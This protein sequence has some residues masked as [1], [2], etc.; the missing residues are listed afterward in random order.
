[1]KK[2]KKSQNSDPI[3]EAYIQA[4]CKDLLKI[5][6]HQEYKLSIVFKYSEYPEKTAAEIGTNTVYLYATLSIYKPV[7]DAWDEND[8]REV[9]LMITHELCHLL[10][11]PQHI[12]TWQ[13]VRAADEAQCEDIRE[14]QTQRIANIILKLLPEGYFDLDNIL[15]EKSSVKCWDKKN[16]HRQKKPHHI[17]LK[18][19][20]QR[21][22]EEG[23]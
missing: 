18:G 20:K 5:I 13:L 14:R 8:L 6:L 17:R 23:L 15:K 12:F 21:T 1:M 4:L 16:T 2:I 19:S 11:E 9:G 10:T 7:K 22:H 3:F